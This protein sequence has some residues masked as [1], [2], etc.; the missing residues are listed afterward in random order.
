MK[1]VTTTPVSTGNSA[2]TTATEELMPLRTK[3]LAKE[4]GIKA[5]AL[6]R[7]LRSMPEY[8][9]GVHTNY[10][11]AEGD[12]R[13]AGIKAQ[14]DKLTAEK[15]KRAA[16][17]KAALAKRVADTAKQAAADVKLAKA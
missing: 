1:K 12:K 10:K 7:V 4:F 14:I 13:I 5:T 8:A 9:D 6:R 11:W 3:H 2:T 15:V 17:A 16:D